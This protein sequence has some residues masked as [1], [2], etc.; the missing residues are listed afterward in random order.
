MI[1]HHRAAHYFGPAQHM[2]GQAFGRRQQLVTRSKHSARK[3]MRDRQDSRPAGAKER[4]RH[5]ASDAVKA[6]SQDRHPD[7][8]DI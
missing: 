3:V 7:A 5:F 2:D 8:I 4:I 1:F 6:S